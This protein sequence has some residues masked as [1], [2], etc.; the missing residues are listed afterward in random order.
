MTSP[1]EVEYLAEMEPITIIPKFNLP[2]MTMIYGDIGP[3]RAGMP[4]QVPLWIG[5]NFR[6]RSKCHIVP[7]DWLNV[8]ILEAVKKEEVS[9]KLF[10]K[11]PS[12]YYMPVAKL[13]FGQCPIDIPD[14]DACKVLVKDIW[15]IR[16]AKLRTSIHFFLDSGSMSAKVD[17][18]TQMEIVSVRPFLPHALEQMFRIQKTLEVTLSHT[19]SL[20]MPSGSSSSARR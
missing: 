16:T 12:E 2:V 18:L 17:H 7:P 11:M 6:S 10:T 3:F 20:M 1:E 19:Q 8:S 15:D 5:L 4:A 9:S 13:L 14:A